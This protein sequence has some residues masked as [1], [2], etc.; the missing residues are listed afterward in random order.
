[1]GKTEKDSHPKIQGV[2][3][4]LVYYGNA[5]LSI[6]HL[7]IAACIFQERNTKVITKEAKV[8]STSKSLNEIEAKLHP[9]DFFRVNRNCIISYFSIERIEPYFGNRLIIFRNCE[10]HPKVIVS[11][12]RVQAFKVWLGD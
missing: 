7:E 10:V 3:R 5:L 11:R 6:R 2:D 1:M 8:Y 9:Q 4:F 12:P